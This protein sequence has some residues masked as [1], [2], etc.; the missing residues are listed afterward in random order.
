MILAAGS[1]A[2]EIAVRNH[3]ELF[4]NAPIVYI[5]ATKALLAPLEPF[6][7]DVVGVPVVY[8]S[9]GTIEQALRWHPNAR[10]L[11]IVTGASPQDVEQTNRM[12]S[13]VARFADRVSIEFISELPTAE[14]EST[15]PRCRPTASCSHPGTTGRG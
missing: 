15:S 10:H 5:G 8:D 12:R 3:A 11:V 7:P 6:P 14:V 4:P 13:K 9:A 1:D 2:V